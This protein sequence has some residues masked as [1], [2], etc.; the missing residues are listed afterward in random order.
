MA[1]QVYYQ[2]EFYEAIEVTAP[3]ESPA[4]FPAKWRRVE[5]PAAFLSFLVARAYS[6]LLPAEGQNDKA[7][8][9]E[10][11]A[12]RILQDVAART[13]ASSGIY[14]DRRPEVGSR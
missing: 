11:K 6:L 2:G 1:S 4:G 3:G 7:A 10:R 9:E 14:A 13:A 8:Q 12:D 5:M